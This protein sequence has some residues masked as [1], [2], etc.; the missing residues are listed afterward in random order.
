M[1]NR[2]NPSAGQT[3]KEWLGSGFLRYEQDLADGLTG[4]PASATVN[5][6]PTTGNCSRPIMARR[7]Q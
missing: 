5:A 4:T 3:R 1:G 6:C 7:A 2:P